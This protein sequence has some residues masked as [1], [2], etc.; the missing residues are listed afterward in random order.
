RQVRALDRPGRRAHRRA[1]ARR[2]REAR[3][4]MRRGVRGASR[5]FAAGLAVACLGALAGCAASRPPPPRAPALST[6]NDAIPPDLDL[7][8]RVDL[9][10]VRAALG[11]EGIAVLR[12]GAASAAGAETGSDFFVRALE[13]ADV[14]CLALRPEL[15][16]GE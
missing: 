14:A 8:I 13:H 2:G 6:P 4:R 1:R 3:V 16:P 9:A 12:R 11:P 15:V 7:V 10:K 5:R